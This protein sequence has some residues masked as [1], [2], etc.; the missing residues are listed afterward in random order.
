MIEVKESKKDV[1]Y[2]ERSRVKLTIMLTTGAALALLFIVLIV[3]V[4]SAEARI[5]TVDDSGG[6]NYT[7]IQ[8]AIDNATEGDTIWVWEGTYYENVVVNKTVSLVGNGSE[9]TTID[10]GGNGSVVK[11]MAAWVN[12]SGFQVTGSGD[13]P[14]NSGIYVE[15]NH[16]QIF[17]NNC[18][19]IHNGITLNYSNDCTLEKN[20]CSNNNHGISLRGS[21]ND[22]T[23]T[24]NICSSNKYGGIG[25]SDYSGLSEYNTLTNNSCSNNGHS[26][27]YIGG[28]R[29][30]LQKNIC[31]SNKR[32]G[33]FSS[34]S[35]NNTI[36]HNICQ[37]NSWNGIDFYRVDT[38][39]LKGNKCLKNNNGIYFDGIPL[40]DTSDNNII[41]SNTC[42]DNNENGIFLRWSPSSNITNNI[43]NNNYA[44][45]I[46]IYASDSSML[47]NNSCMNNSGPEQYHYGIF[48]DG[49]SFDCTVS[50]NTCFYNPRG[51]GLRD[52]K[53]INLTNNKCCFNFDV[54]IYIVD[55]DL[56]N[57]INNTCSN[58]HYGIALPSSDSTSLSNNTCSNNDYGIYLHESNSNTLSNNTIHNNNIGICLRGWD[59]YSRDNTAH[60]NNIY[61]NT[62]YGI[63]ASNNNDYTINATDSWWGASSGPY[64]PV[65]NTDGKGDNITDYVLFD[66]WLTE[67][68][69]RSPTANAGNDQTVYINKEVWFVGTGEDPDGTIENYEWDFD[70]DGTFDWS[71]STTGE[72]THLYSKKGTYHAVLQVTDDDGA[73][74]TD[75]CTITVKEESANEKPTITITEPANNSTVSGTVTINGT[76]SDPNGDETIERV[77]IR[78]NHGGWAGVTGTTSWSYQWDTTEVEEGNHTIYARAFD[79]EEYS[80][81]KVWNLIVDNVPENTRP[82]ISITSPANNTTVSGTVTISGTASDQDG[83]ETIENVEISINSGEWETA[84]GTASWTFEWNTTA[85]VNGEYSLKFKAF[86][87]EDFSEIKEIILDVQNVQE[88]TRP[89]ITITSPA[90][91]S[92]VSGIVT[93][94]GTTSDPEGNET[95][96][97]V[98]ISIDGGAWIE[99]T[100]TTSWSF[101]WDTAELDNGE[102]FLRIRAF[103][104]EDFSEILEINLDVQNVL[105]NTKPTITITFPANNSEVS[106]IVTV[107]GTASDPDG[108]ETIESVEV[109]INSGAWKTATGTTSWTFEL[110][111]TTL[112]NGEYSL[113]F[114]AF[115]GEDFSEIAEFTLNV[116]KP[117]PENKKPTVSI[118]TP[119]DGEKVSG[120]ITISGSASDSDGS[121][122]KVEVSINGENWTSITGIT[123]WSFEW[124][125]KELKNGDYTIRVR[126]F[127]GTNH[128][129]VKE[130]TVTVENKDDDDGGGGGFIP[131]F[132]AVAVVVAV[133][134]TLVLYRMKGKKEMVR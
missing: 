26:G 46:I 5:I 83:N 98:V 30:T 8:D 89:T 62:E 114:R 36:I 3:M 125:T 56:S 24:N 31:D 52:S 2:M 53:R 107:N 76:A 22:C 109:S 124:D 57:I 59:E 108:D 34:E 21:S 79:G 95:I 41:M 105:E 45:G 69:N 19:N 7:K 50:N 40:T 80:D 11:I 134:V 17:E 97:K 111:T 113:K 58:S 10:G 82:T 73:T 121:V 130:I 77:E 86:D 37:N 38:S 88:N 131:G 115:D 90:N 65:N 120:K 6:A 91:N 126:S 93:I 42:S 4:G 119:P 67:P 123:S 127:D 116:Q 66:P 104:G 94:N 75:G 103:D 122:E 128:S 14:W 44:D 43:C 20:T 63:D 99:A 96:E 132:G 129:E 117:V 54:G 28:S 110:D 16:N 92:E 15:S 55:S 112:E 47:M 118:T 81:V 61:N 12:I 29:N 106:G 32:H 33:I 9:V 51:I 25:L 18:S 78:I 100:G 74:A 1:K 84:T 72:T 35:N 13:D 27:I 70:G 101:Q 23:I 64:H 71:S 39:L 102:Y 85:L 48:L 49:C 60:Y 133:G 87:G 68:V